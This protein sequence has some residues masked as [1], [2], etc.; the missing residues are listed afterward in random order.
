MQHLGRAQRVD[1]ARGRPVGRLKRHRS[2]IA[3]S[4]FSQADNEEDEEALNEII[5]FVRV[6]VLLL[7]A[8]HGGPATPAHATAGTSRRVH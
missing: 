2:A 4:D 6:S 8:E 5:E 1:A 3:G 7:Y